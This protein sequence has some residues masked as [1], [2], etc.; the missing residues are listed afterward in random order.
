MKTNVFVRTKNVKGFVN[1]MSE[2]ENLPPKIPKIA[3]VDM[4]LVSQKQLN[5]GLL[6]MTVFM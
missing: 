3:T 6:E 2:L 5:G 4:D 1:L